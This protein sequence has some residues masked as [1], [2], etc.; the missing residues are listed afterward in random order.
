MF[1]SFFPAITVR[2]IY[3]LVTAF[4]M[5]ILMGPI[6]I[7]RMRVRQFGQAI[8]E[9]GPQSH[10]SK[11][12]VPT[13]GGM[14]ILISIIV[15]CLMWSRSVVQIWVATGA[16]VW[17]GTL[18]FTDDLLKLIK[19][20]SKG[21]SAFGKL[22]WQAAFG[23]A[24]GFFLYKGGMG[25]YLPSFISGDAGKTLLGCSAINMPFYG[26]VELGWA[27]VPFVA[28]VV[29][30]ASNAVN[31]T[32]GLDGLAMGTLI[33]VSIAYGGISYVIGNI[34]FSEHLRLIYVPGSGELTIFCASIVGAGLGF[35]WFNS[36][37]A[38]IFMGDTGSLAIGGAV[39]TVAVMVKC[40]LILAVVGGIFVVEAL[41]VILQVASFKTT[42]QRIFRMAPIHH[43][44]E[45]IGWPESKVVLRFWIIAF[46][47][48]LIGI[49]ILG[50]SG[51]YLSKVPLSGVTA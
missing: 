51:M 14:L 29:V 40:E 3:A 8:R 48:A 9:D 19:K 11:K 5:T 43:H 39:G 4:G 12:G 10:L 7:E 49:S 47:L 1:S 23:M 26:P 45:L 24:L 13:M 18:G 27:F 30:G 22:V 2:T 17:L 42:G 31:L 32:D 44:F 35:L 21:V 46:I 20:N 28:L 38:Q 41:S 37:P 16:L 25:E 15:T 34:K 36:Y 50:V 33:V 6:M